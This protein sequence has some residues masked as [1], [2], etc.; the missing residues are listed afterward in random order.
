[1][2]RG[3]YRRV[4]VRLLREARGL[5]RDGQERLRQADEGIAR[6]AAPLPAPA[7]G[8]CCESC[9]A[10]PAGRR[11]AGCLCLRLHPAPPAATP[12]AATP[13]A[14]TPPAATPPAPAGG[15]PSAAPETPPAPEAAPGR[16]RLA[17]GGCS[18]WSAT[19][20]TTRSSTR[21]RASFICRRS[22]LKNLR[23]DEIEIPLEQ[24]QQGGPAGLSGEETRYRLS[25]GA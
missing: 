8:G 22:L 18:N 17:R 25:G 10:I 2:Q 21:T 13:P 15:A 20:T 4:R 16:V 11:N 3:E 19:T 14:A 6:P 1:M 9:P 23:Q 5:V 12:P 7:G 24:R